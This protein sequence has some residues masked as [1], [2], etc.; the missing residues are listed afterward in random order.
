MGDKSNPKKYPN[1]K[2]QKVHIAESITGN[3]DPLSV[4]YPLPVD[5]DSI[6]AKD[7]NEDISDLGNFSGSVFDFFDNLHSENVD[8]TENNPK[9]L[10]IH[11]NR[12]VVSPLVGLGSSEGG[13]FSNVRVIGVLS[14]GVQSVLADSSLDNTKRT[15]QFFQ[16]PNSGLNAIILEFHTDDPVA[17][18]NIF[19]PKIVP[20]SA[21]S[22]TVVKYATSYKSPY[23]L[24]VGSQDMTVDGSIIPIDFVYTVSGLTR[25]LWQRSFIDLT[26]GTQNFNSENF[27]AITG[28]LLNGVDIIVNKSG[29]ETVLE[30]WKTNMD[31]SMTCYDFSSPYRQG[32]Y[33][34]RWTITSDMGSPITLFNG[35]QIILRV[36]DNLT[37]LDSFR[38]RVKLS[39]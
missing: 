15:T 30:N 31:I 12:T 32:E 14:G 24:N 25:A 21:I 1:Q 33:I 20:V 11:F 13:N 39:Q 7:V 22:E 2:I 3:A 37:S 26:D 36:R 38:F 27:G 19:I 6:H 35:D 17:L 23:L 9:T 5:G 28:G 16:F 4:N 8:N 10:L 18:T 29:I 34:G